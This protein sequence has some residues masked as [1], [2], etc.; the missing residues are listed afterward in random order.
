[1]D[2]K[3][4]EWQSDFAKTHQ[5]EGYARGYARGL[6]RAL[7]GMLEARGIGVSDDI[8]ERVTNCDDI[9][10]LEHWVQRAAIS[11]TAENIFN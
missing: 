2:I 4:Y 8:R 3:N 6:R 11:S 9:E 5:A 7:L 10:Q 1:M